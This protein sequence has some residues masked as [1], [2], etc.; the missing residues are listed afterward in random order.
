VVLAASEGE[1]VLD[2]VGIE[3]VAQAA[4]KHGRRW[5]SFSTKPPDLFSVTR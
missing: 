5:M 1:L 2:P 3:A 4:A